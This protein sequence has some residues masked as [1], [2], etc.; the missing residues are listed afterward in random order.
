ML[1]SFRTLFIALSCT[2]FVACTSINDAPLIAPEQ[3]TKSS[4]STTP[5]QQ[6]PPAQVAPITKESSSMK[7]R[8]VTPRIIEVKADNWNFSPNAITVKKGENVVLRFTGVSGAHS[9]VAPTLGIKQNVLPGDTIEVAL[10]TETIGT[11]KFWCG[12]P[13]GEGHRDMIGTITIQ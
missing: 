8:P 10:T 9:I 6:D 5:E 7:Q 4:A 13:C 2:S 11:H 1:I 3:P 12:I